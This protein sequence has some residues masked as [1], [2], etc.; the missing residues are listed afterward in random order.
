ME[1]IINSKRFDRI[2]KY[3]VRWKAYDNT[4]DTWEPIQNLQQ[5]M[6][7]VKAFHRTEPSAAKHPMV[8]L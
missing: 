7:I 1:A 3:R 4:D 6:D 5:V 2:I 8:A